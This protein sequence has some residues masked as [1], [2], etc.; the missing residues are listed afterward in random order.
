LSGEFWHR[1]I[2]AFGTYVMGARSIR[3]EA[4]ARVSRN[5]GR[6]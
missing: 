1:G 2:L 5:P 4:G 3:S 6:R